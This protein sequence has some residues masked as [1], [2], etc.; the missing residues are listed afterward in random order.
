MEGGGACNLN[1]RA[2]RAMF[3]V[4]RRGEER[5]RAGGALIALDNVVR[6]RRRAV[7]IA[8]GTQIPAPSYEAG[9]ERVWAVLQGESGRRHLK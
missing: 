6:G 3:D 2:G 5:P 8:R 7:R 4:R 1:T 9:Y